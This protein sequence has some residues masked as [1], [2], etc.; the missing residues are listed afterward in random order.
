MALEWFHIIW[1]LPGLRIHV[2]GLACEQR[3]DADNQGHQEHC[4]CAEIHAHLRPTWRVALI[5]AELIHTHSVSQE[6]NGQHR[7]KG[8]SQRRG[9]ENL[10]NGNVVV[11]Q[12]PT[13]SGHSADREGCV[14][15]HELNSETDH[16]LHG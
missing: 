15:K 5:L 11:L 16:A 10:L 13:V 2:D 14:Y 8:N 9:L 1:N 12:S 3:N 7:R 6:K 4:V